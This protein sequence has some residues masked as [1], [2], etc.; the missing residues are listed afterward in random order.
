MA[1][2][3]DEEVMTMT[4]DHSMK[5]KRSRASTLFEVGVEYYD[6]LALLTPNWFRVSVLLSV[7]VIGIHI[8][9]Y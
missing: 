1:L 7:V 9:L 8:T 6:F 4:G 3:E 5:A 2:H